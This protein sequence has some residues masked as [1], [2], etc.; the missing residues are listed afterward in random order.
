MSAF[1]FKSS[2]TR[3]LTTQQRAPTDTPIGKPIAEAVPASAKRVGVWA[4]YEGDRFSGTKQ[5]PGDTEVKLGSDVKPEYFV[6][7]QPGK[8]TE[9]TEW[10]DTNN[11]G[12]ADLSRT[13]NENGR[14]VVRPANLRPG[15]DLKPGESI[16]AD[17]DGDGRIDSFTEANENGERSIQDDNHDGKVDRIVEDARRIPDFSFD[18]VPQS[19]VANRIFEDT[20]KDGS[21]DSEAVTARRQPR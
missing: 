15:E 19:E 3:P 17:H 5:L 18:G 9:L 2:L 16:S 12:R 20:N 4:H 7:A 8:V 13:T 6:F 14:T 21:F 10:F 11:D 1:G